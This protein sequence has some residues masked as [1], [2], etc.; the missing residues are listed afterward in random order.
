MGDTGAAAVAVMLRA[1]ATL[2]ALDIRQN[3][4]SCAGRSTLMAALRAARSSA[5]VSLAADCTAAQGSSDAALG[6]PV[7]FGFCTRGRLP[8]NNSAVF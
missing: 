2:A 3:G 4:L 5:L 8:R 7:V 6:I 1:N